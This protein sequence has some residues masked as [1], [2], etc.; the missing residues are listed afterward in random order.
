MTGSSQGEGRLN[1][2]PGFAALAALLLASCGQ[3]QSQTVDLSVAEVQTLL[4]QLPGDAD[5]MSLATRYPGT[6]YRVEPAADQVVWIFMRDGTGEYGRYIAE[7]SA[8]GP[9][10]TIVTTRFNDGPA[11]PNLTFLDDVAKIAAD[12]SVAAALQARPVD[13]ATVQNE[14]TQTMMKNP[15]AAHTAAV[16]TVS[17]EPP[18]PCD[19]PS[20]EDLR[21]SPFC[22]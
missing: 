17:D 5:A 15:M 9:N 20:R 4:L 6:S 19:D 3:D 2:T 11:D 7:L 22:K 10:K 21:D 8:D 14:I 13:M 16:E 12:A 1:R 18:D